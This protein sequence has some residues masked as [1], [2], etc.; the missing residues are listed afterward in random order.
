MCTYTVPSSLEDPRL[1]G[2]FMPVLILALRA[3]VR[4]MEKE[5]AKD[6][7]KAWKLTAFN[8]KA[9]AGKGLAETINGASVELKIFSIFL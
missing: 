2:F 3:P 8:V 4:R 5:H 1:P 7:A 6:F 9:N